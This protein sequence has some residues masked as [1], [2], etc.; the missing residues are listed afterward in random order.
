MSTTPYV[1]QVING[2]TS[3]AVAHCP[4]RVSMRLRD[5]PCEHPEEV[6]LKFD[7]MAEYAIERE[8]ARRITRDEAREIIQLSAREGL[9]HFVDNAGS[10]VKH[11]CNCCG[12]ACWN[13][14]TIR[15]RKVPRDT[16]MAA[17]F[18]R[19][20][21]PDRCTGCGDCVEICPVQAVLRG[22]GRVAVD[23]EW[24]IGCG[25]CATRCGFDAC[26]M[27]HREDRGEVPGEFGALHRDILREKVTK[28]G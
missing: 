6:C 3:F 18:L 5:R 1:E 28:T 15:R 7:E 21:D 2:A 22:D 4:C 23:L 27:I 14:G 25:V 10:G 13:V 9:V 11:N 20:T 12:C 26:A 24:C 8:L 16:L 17:Y 19:E